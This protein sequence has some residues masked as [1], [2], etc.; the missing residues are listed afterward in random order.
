ML[1]LCSFV[2]FVFVDEGVWVVFCLFFDCGVEFC[3]VIF[4]LYDVFIE[5]CVMVVCFDRLIICVY[6]FEVRDLFVCGC[7]L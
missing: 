7:V 5:V 4:C 1:V 6:L 2:F 3:V